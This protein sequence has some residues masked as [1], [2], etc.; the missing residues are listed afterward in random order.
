MIAAQR[1]EM[2]RTPA[3]CRQG[4]KLSGRNQAGHVACSDWL[5]CGRRPR[6]RAGRIPGIIVVILTF[7]VVLSYIG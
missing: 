4:A 7:V 3:C 1:R 2:S 5:D 6:I